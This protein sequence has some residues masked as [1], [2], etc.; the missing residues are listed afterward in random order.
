MEG[1]ERRR[2]GAAGGGLR[3]K[4]MR[5]GKKQLG[6]QDRDGKIRGNVD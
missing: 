4:S 1:G 5:G 2:R 6:K 3:W